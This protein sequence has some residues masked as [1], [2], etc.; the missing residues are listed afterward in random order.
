MRHYAFARYF[1]CIHP[2]A[3]TNNE[4]QY[5]YHSNRLHSKLAFQPELNLE[6]LYFYGLTQ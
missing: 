5:L 3:K 1:L 4:L 2:R 6:L